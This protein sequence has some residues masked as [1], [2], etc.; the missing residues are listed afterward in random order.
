MAGLPVGAPNE[1]GPSGSSHALPR[2]LRYPRQLL[3]PRGRAAALRGARRCPRSCAPATSW[4]TG[5]NPMNASNDSSSSPIP[6]AGNH[7]PSSPLTACPVHSRRFSGTPPSGRRGPLARTPRL[8]PG[9]PTSVR[10]RRPSPTARSTI[11]RNRRPKRPG[12]RPA[13]AAL[14]A[15]GHGPAGQWPGGGGGPASRPCACAPVAALLDARR[16]PSPCKRKYHRAKWPWLTEQPGGS[17]R[18]CKLHQEGRPA[19]QARTPT[20]RLT[21]RAGRLAPP[22]PDTEPGWARR[23]GSRCASQCE[24]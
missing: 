7:D 23:P 17:R 6:V 18:G 9:A 11:R 14:K 10:R 1:P 19:P 5:R 2:R 13:R 8:L 15:P 16:S 20:S 3:R 12:P 24:G 22:Q 21:C 4:A